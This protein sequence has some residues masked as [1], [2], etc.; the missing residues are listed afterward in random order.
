MEG[1][2]PLQVSGAAPAEL[3]EAVRT[4]KSHRHSLAATVRRGHRRT[5]RQ[6]NT[7]IYNEDC[8]VRGNNNSNNNHLTSY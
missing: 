7:T 8:I 3:L 4:A 1:P 5:E 2:W 6:I